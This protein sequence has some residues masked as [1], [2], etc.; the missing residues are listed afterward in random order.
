MIKRLNSI[1]AGSLLLVSSTQGQPADLPAV[2]RQLAIFAGILEESLQLNESTGLFGMSLGGVESLYLHAQGAV[3][4]IRTPL[5]N[6]RNRMGLASLSTAMQALQLR[7]NPF[8]SISLN[9]ERASDAQAVQLTEAASSENTYRQLL[10][11]IAAI[12]YSA[13]AQG[14]MQQASQSARAL[15]ALDSVDDT[16][17]A[18]LNAEIAQMR[19]S[20]DGQ[21]SNLR[22]LEREIREQVASNSQASGESFSTRLDS[23][24]QSME[25]IKDQALEKANDL[26]AQ[27]EQAELDYT[28]AWQR[29]LVEFQQNLYRSLCDYGDTLDALATSDSVSVILK[30]LGE[31]QGDN[32]RTDLIHIVSNGSILACASGE[33]SV[34]ELQETAMIYTY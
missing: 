16:A 23:L 15:R 12:D 27:V 21:L 4:E 30:G 8:Q 2:Q 31:D 29:D 24:L 5:A 18:D 7:Q 32:R 20:L 17:F 22:E 33:I 3:F 34:S 26:R 10:D 13:I 25:P 1:V 11:R 19:D 6:R 9:A 28:Q 14:A